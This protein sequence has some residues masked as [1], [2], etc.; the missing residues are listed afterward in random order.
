MRSR[1]EPVDYRIHKS[2]DDCSGIKQRE[3]KLLAQASQISGQRHHADD[4]PFKASIY[5]FHIWVVQVSE[6]PAL[7]GRVMLAVHLFGTEALFMPTYKRDDVVQ[8]N[9][10]KADNRK[11]EKKSIVG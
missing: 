2:E 7:C 5:L 11:V 3:V 1:N 9:Q 4:D 10:D 8:E 6:G